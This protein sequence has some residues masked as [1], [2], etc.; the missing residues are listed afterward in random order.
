MSKENED[1]SITIET[2]LFKPKKSE[3][4]TGKTC[5]ACLY[6]FN[7]PQDLKTCQCRRHAP[8][9]VMAEM[10]QPGKPV[11]TVPQSIFPAMK[12]DGFCGEW[13]DPKEW[14]EQKDNEK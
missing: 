1:K 10:H 5:G 13:T 9:V 12:R 3:K 7:I 6:G 11:I 2:D 14:K 8:I 4:P